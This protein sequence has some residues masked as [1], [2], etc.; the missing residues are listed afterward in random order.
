MGATFVRSRMDSE[1]TQFTDRMGTLFGD[2]GQP[3]DRRTDLRLSAP[4][5]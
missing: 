5:R 3:P 4:E 2:E 1:T